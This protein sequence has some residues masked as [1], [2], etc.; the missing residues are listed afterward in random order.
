MLFISLQVVW[1]GKDSWFSTHSTPSHTHPPTHSTQSEHTKLLSEH[2]SDS[3][4]NH[5]INASSSEFRQRRTCR[6]YCVTVVRGVSLS[7]IVTGLTTFAVGFF[8]RT[9]SF[10][11]ILGPLSCLCV[12]LC[13]NEYYRLRRSKICIS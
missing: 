9:M 4:N 7:Y 8:L 2:I 1:Y 3:L 6:Y 11:A 12:V 13:A 10:F 5:Q